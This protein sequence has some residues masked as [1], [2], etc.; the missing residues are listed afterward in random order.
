MK[1]RKLHNLSILLASAALLLTTSACSCDEKVTESAAVADEAA[2]DADKKPAAAEAPKAEVAEAKIP[3]SE[4]GSLFVKALIDF[5]KYDVKDAEG[6]VV[7]TGD[8][9]ISTLKLVPGVYTVAVKPAAFDPVS[10]GEVEIKKGEVVQAAFKGFAELMGHGPAD[11]I[12]Y[13]ILNAKGEIVGKGDTNISKMGLPMGI[14]SVV[15]KPGKFGP[16]KIENIDLKDG[17]RKH[18]KLPGFGTVKVGG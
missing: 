9:N 12:K 8:T 11:F 18:V 15:F 2:P 3:D 17:E 1:T 14:Y 6:K 4:K 5:T 10:L 16:I 13:D 7:A